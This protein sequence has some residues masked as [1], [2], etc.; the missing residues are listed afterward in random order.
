M[1]VSA[2]LVDKLARLSRLSFADETEKEKIR[3]D[4]NKI[5]QFVEQLNEVNTDGVEPLIFINEDI[6]V[7]RTDEVVQQLNRAEALKNAPHKNED[8]FLVP[9]VINKV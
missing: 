2:E 4:L 9:K 6:N 1:E 5:L 3:N 8:Y 7:L